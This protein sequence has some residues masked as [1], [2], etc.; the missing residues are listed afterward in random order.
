MFEFVAKQREKHSI[1]K[2]EHTQDTADDKYTLLQCTV[3]TDT[4]WSLI[5]VVRKFQAKM[6]F[7]NGGLCAQMRQAHTIDIPNFFAYIRRTVRTRIKHP[8]CK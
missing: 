5:R 7:V 8:K 4:L 1:S 3:H 2:R 6:A